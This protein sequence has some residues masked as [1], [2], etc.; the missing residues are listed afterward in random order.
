TVILYVTL[1]AGAQ[2]V[3]G[4]ILKLYRGK[5]R[6]GSFEESLGLLLSMVIVALALIIAFVLIGG[7]EFFPRSIALLSPPFALTLMAAGR[8]AYRAWTTPKRPSTADTENVLI[9]GAGDAGYQLLR[10][11]EMDTSSPYRVVG[12]I[13][14]DPAKRHLNLFNVPVLG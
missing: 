5:Y 3:V 13:D 6:V 2:L 12:F 10:L 8:W 14:D 4:T 1:A 11:I 7:L 9:Y